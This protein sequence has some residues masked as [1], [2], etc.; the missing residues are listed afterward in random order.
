ML[1]CDILV[2]MATK[3]FVASFVDPWLVTEAECYIG[4]IILQNNS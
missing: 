1:N 3:V 4:Q 2:R